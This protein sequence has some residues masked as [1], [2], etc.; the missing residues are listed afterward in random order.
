M[1]P[2]GA[3]EMAAFLP[4]EVPEL[5]A[6]ARWERYDGRVKG[7]EGRSISYVL[8]VDPRYQALYRLTRYRVTIVTRTAE[9]REERRH[10]A[11]TL[12]WNSKPGSGEPLHCYTLTQ[13]VDGPAR[14][15]TVAHGS[16]A[17]LQAMRT[18]I[19]IYSELGTQFRRSIR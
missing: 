17:Y 11:E 1:A 5:G 12:V 15:Q 2:I 9:G 19:F 8:Y 3:S 16:E 4:E 10:E 14:W 18:S 13:D 6:L 7:V